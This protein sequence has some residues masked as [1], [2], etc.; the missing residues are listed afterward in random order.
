MNTPPQVEIRI[1]Q[2]RK[3][4]PAE[5]YEKKI[6][7]YVDEISDTD[8]SVYPPVLINLRSLSRDHIRGLLQDQLLSH[9]ND[10]LSLSLEREISRAATAL[11][12]GSNGFYLIISVRITHQTVV[13]NSEELLRMVLLGSKMNTEELKS[14]ETEPCS[15][16]LDELSCS[17]SKKT[18]VP[19]RMTCSHVFH[20]RC[21]IEWLQRK[22]TCPLC[23]S[24][25]YDR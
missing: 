13:V 8:R 3:L 16:C 11:G 24:V 12:F 9:H 23:R 19:T 4:F 21:L 2:A 17:D 22:N 1:L 14:M 15:I 18:G 7:I 10:L 25:L 6:I 5:G 20:D